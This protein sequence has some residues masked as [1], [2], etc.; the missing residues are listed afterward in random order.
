[1]LDAWQA[2]ATMVKV[3]PVHMFGTE[4]L[5][6][7]RGP[8]DNA[9]LLACGGVR[10]T[11]VAEYFAAGADAVTIGAHTFKREWLEQGRFDLLED[12]VSRIV[13]GAR[14]AIAAR[15]PR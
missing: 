1:V 10:A 5:R 8:F 11:N 9:P 12:E 4:Y 14:S 3:F 2:G 6:E 7:L 15:A 13:A